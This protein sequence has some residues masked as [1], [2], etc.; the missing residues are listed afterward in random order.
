MELTD[1]ILWLLKQAFHFSLKTVNDAISSHG[2]T[3]AQ[4]GLMRQLANEPGLSGAELARRLMISPQGVQLAITALER[5]GLV[6]RKQD[7]QHGRI[8]QAYLTDQGR[9]VVSA[10]LADALAA[11]ERVFGVLDADERQLLHD[12]LARVVEEG[13]GNPLFREQG[14]DESST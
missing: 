10:V 2:V 11:H 13:T 9:A 1:N 6:E 8:L 7:P 3:T 5:R 4:I 12:L 14:D